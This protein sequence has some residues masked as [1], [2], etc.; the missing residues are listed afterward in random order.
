LGGF[1]ITQDITMRKRAEEEL[2]NLAQQRQLALDTVRM[3]WWQYDPVTR[4]ASWDDG[5]RRIFGVS[6][7]RSPYE[8]ILARIHPDDL[9]GVCAGVEAAL[10]PVDPQPYSAEYRIG[11]P[12]GSTRWVEAHGVASFEGAGENRR[13][14]SL[15]GTV[16]DVTD[17]KRAEEERETT[18]EF[19]RLANRSL[20]SVD[21]VRGAADF[22]QRRSGCEGAGIRLA[23]DGGYPY[24]ETR[25][26]RKEFV[27]LRNGLCARDGNGTHAVDDTGRPVPECMC[28]RVI[29]GR[30]DPSEPYFTERGSFWTNSVSEL[31]RSPARPERA[32]LEGCVEEGFESLALIAISSGD[33]KMGL[34]QLADRRRGRFAPDTI[35]LWERLADSLA[36]ALSKH[37]AKEALL[38]LNQKLEQRVTERTELAEA[39]T[40]QLQA[41][42]VDLIDAKEEERRRIAQLLHDDLQQVLAAARMQLTLAR[43]SDS[44]ESTLNGVDRLIQESIDKSRNLARELSPPVLRHSGLAA[45]LEWL[46]C[47]M[48]EQHGLTVELEACDLMRR[49]D[50]AVNAFIF[51]AVQELLFN[52]VKHA[53]VKRARVALS[54]TGESLVVEVSDRGRGFDPSIMSPTAAAAG[55]GL[56]SLRE[57]AS[58]IRGGLEIES[59]PG[60]GSRFTLTLPVRLAGDVKNLRREPPVGGQ[61]ARAAGDPAGSGVKRV[62]V[63]F[64]DDHAV[65]RQG[66]IKLVEGKP[67]IEIAGEAADGLEALALVRRLVPDVVV[68]DVSM[69]GMDGVEATRLIKAEHPGVRVIGLSMHDDDELAGGMLDAGAEAFVNKAVS[70]AEL[71]EAIYGTSRDAAPRGEG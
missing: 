62:R 60:R 40:R 18:V 69:P 47:Q 8:E 44:C 41:L 29:D 42:A 53:G 46:C 61:T 45:A 66:L 28:A 20:S 35:S 64:A 67:G 49:E 5:Y 10:D 12:N 22:F 33:E 3:G 21:L 39:R 9:P 58:H 55:F 54:T 70:S 57:R 1:G 6:G 65:I 68:M 34:L 51:R 15:V 13:A 50:Q 4:I 27:A 59:A 7:Y 14:A 56:L 37:A 30:F 19:L 32:A 36:V 52:V 2:R 25:G 24:R 38:E 16:A 23:R 31:S 71:L 48:G 43:G 17:R 26:F 11:L 63:L